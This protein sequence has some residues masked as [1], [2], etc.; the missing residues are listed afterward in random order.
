MFEKA[1]AEKEVAKHKAF[2]ALKE[3]ELREA[4][5]QLEAAIKSLLELQRQAKQANVKVTEVTN[6]S[7]K[8]A[9]I[10]TPNKPVVFEENF[11]NDGSFLFGFACFFFS[12]IALWIL[13]LALQLQATAAFPKL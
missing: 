3:K 5:L 11:P 10:P 9:T 4:K 6:K 13:T 1:E 2:V 12:F 7:E 8:K